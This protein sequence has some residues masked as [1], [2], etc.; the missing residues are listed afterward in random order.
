MQKELLNVTGMSCDGCA[1]KV[2]RALQAVNG[3][4][5]VNVSVSE[6]KVAVQ[7]DERLTSSGQLKAAV[8]RAGYSVEPAAVPARPGKGC[9]CGQLISR[10]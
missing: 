7:F 6:G 3:V 5:E 10:Q 2:T 1:G 8:R 4:K 9:C